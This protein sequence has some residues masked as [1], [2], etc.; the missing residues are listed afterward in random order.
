MAHW[1]PARL[2]DLTGQVHVVT[3]AT[4]GIGLET[5]RGLAGQGARVVLAVRDEARGARARAQVGGD[6]TV[7]RLD[8]ADLDAVREF[9]DA[10]PA[11]RVAGLVCNAGVM[12]GPR[13]FTTQGHE[14]QMGT[15][16]VGHAELV[17]LLW[18][19]LTA[20]AGRVV[21]VSSIAARGGRLSAT[22]TR[23]DLVDP[24]P[25]DPGQVYANTKQADLLLAREL[26]R[27]AAAAGSPVSAVAAHPG[28]SATNLFVRTQ[29]EYGRA[30][31][32]PFVRV[33]QRV[34][35][36]SARDGALPSL[37]ALDPA[38]PSGA[39]VGPR[40]LNQARGR[41]ELLDVYPTGS[42]PAVAARLWEL[43]EDVL[44]HRL[45]V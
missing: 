18:P 2:G 11:D 5:A 24:Q 4:S 3:G 15:N 34:V 12:A 22:S 33:L 19:R 40:H 41:P 14:R 27:R 23:A 16:L 38:T 9:A 1:T 10:L 32:V 39:F 8:L 28:V 31:A 30:W 21:M 44:G 7:V 13:M 25:Y 26:H 37:R 29:Q 42:D 43:T 17:S 45:P 20:A 36:M 35:L 6:S